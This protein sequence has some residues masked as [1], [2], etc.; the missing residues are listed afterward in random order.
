MH[1]RPQDSYLSQ[2]TTRQYEEEEGI[3]LGA[4]YSYIHTLCPRDPGGVRH[5]GRRPS[6]DFLLS[7]CLK[8]A[9][10]LLYL[11]RRKFE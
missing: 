11:P 3:L 6:G 9:G 1:E 8:Q 7:R 5:Q 10:S 2:I 4:G